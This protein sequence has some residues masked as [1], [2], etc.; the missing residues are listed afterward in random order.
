MRTKRLLIVSDTRMQIIDGQCYAFN[1]VV[2]E[3]DVF[4]QLFDEITWIAF[5]Y[6]EQE[7]DGT[8]MKVEYP[9]VRPVLWPVSGGKNVKSKFNILIN[10]PFYIAS[11]IGELRKTDVVHSRGPSVPMLLTVIASF[12]Y[13]RN[14][15]WFKYATNWNDKVSSFAY[16]VQ[17]KLILLNRNVKVTING[18]WQGQPNHILSFFN[19][20][21]NE[22]QLEIGRNCSLRKR[23]MPPFRIVF[24]GRV[25]KFKGID[26][27]IDSL[28]KLNS[29]NI[30]HIDIVGDGD[31]LTV[32]SNV[33]LQHGVS[34]TAHG[35]VSQER[36]FTI[37]E[38]S[39]IVLLPSRSEGFPKVV[40]E[41]MAYGCIPVVSPV[42]SI[43]QYIQHDIYGV[44]LEELNTAAL[45]RA[46]NYAF[47]MPDEK[48]AN[49]REKALL[50][51]RNFTYTEYL[52]RIKTEILEPAT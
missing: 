20:C 24:V 16:K 19:P 9:N 27:L 10:M 44:L 11:L 12:V 36:L 1:S 21:I 25:D 34:F 50:M 7:L 45:I 8:Y 52:N 5:D 22:A 26:L 14:L 38:K 18:T 48:R 33:L 13:R 41:A 4:V 46:L 51:A 17:R 3:L 29:D 6:S 49:M 15:Y 47:L 2:K 35:F 42:G 28:S 23:N 30:E 43:P 31:L 40:A 39:D 32:L 37:L